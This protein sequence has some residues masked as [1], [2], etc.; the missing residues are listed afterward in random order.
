MSDSNLK[1]LLSG[2]SEEDK[3]T[4]RELLE[5]ETSEE[6]AEVL[7]NTQ[8]ETPQVKVATVKS[9]PGLLA[10]MVVTVVV[11]LMITGSALYYYDKNYAVHV[12]TCDLRS[13]LTSLKTQV[14]DRKITNEQV[15]KSI[16]EMHGKIQAQADKGNTIVLLKEVVLGGD[17]NEIKP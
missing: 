8:E 16:Q 15:T 6:R 7:S 4:M 5:K 1:D 9:G 3:A 14:G 11:S 13:F 10:N 12:Q 2:M 17:E